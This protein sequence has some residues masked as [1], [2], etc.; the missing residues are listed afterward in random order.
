MPVYSFMNRETE[1][2][3]EVNM[4]FAEL[5]SYIQ[6][7]PQYKQVFVRFPGTA[8]PVRLG[9]RKPDEGFRDVLKTVKSHHKRNEIN[10]W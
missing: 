10:S 1:E 5:E 8:D 6:N 2:V 9:L 4:K 3:F 7:N